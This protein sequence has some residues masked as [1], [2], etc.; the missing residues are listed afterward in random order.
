MQGSGETVSLRVRRGSSSGSPGSMRLPSGMMLQRGGWLARAERLLRDV[1]PGAER[2]WLDL[3]RSERTRDGEESS[4]LASQALDVALQAGDTDLELRALAQLGFAEVAL[5]L[6][7]QGLAHLDEAMAAATSGEPATLE[8]FADVCCTL[9]LACERAGDADRPQQW[10]RVLEEFVRRYDH[11]TLLAFCR[12]CCADVFAANGRIDAAEEELV[13]AIRELTEA[14]QRSRCIPPATRLAEIRVLQGR[15]DEAEQLLVG[16]ADDPDAIRA[17]VAM[18][19]ARGEAQTAEALLVRR[20]DE[21]GWDNLLAAALLEQL[22]QARLAEGMVEEARAAADTLGALAGASGRERVEAAAALGRG[23]VASAAG[24]ADAVNILQQAVNGFARLGLRLEVAQARLDLARALAVQSPPAAIETARHA[25][26]EL[27]ALGASRDAD[28]A[29][30][31]MRSLGAR[32]RAGP[33]SFG[34]LSRREV[35][36]LRLLGEGL[37]NREIADRLFISPKTAEHHV[38]RVY[39]KLGLKSRAEAAGYA[40][41]TLGQ[42]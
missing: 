39:A 19:V 1:A 33:R 3:A 36:V 4:R 26:N 41:R 10:S 27:E 5:G 11:V 38:S 9:M 30:A 23:R 28:A 20:L 16:F 8:T 24:E 21:I 15:F 2:G 14:G 29:A 17:S 32:G 7:D 18:R 13:A 35:E 37:S 22:V 40:V 31:L 12:T 6:V 34:S 42:K 25:R